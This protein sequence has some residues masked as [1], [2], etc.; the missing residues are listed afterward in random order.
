[1]WSDNDID[2]AF[3]RLNP[4][5]PEPAPFPLD[6]WLRLETQ[7]DKRLIEHAVRRKLWRIFA[8]EVAAVALVASAWWLW[9]NSPGATPAA[10]AGAANQPREAL[11]PAAGANAAGATSRGRAVKPAP[12]GPAPAGAS[13]SHSGTLASSYSPPTMRAAA[14]PEAVGPVNPAGA[15]PSPATTRAPRAGIAAKLVAGA[16]PTARTQTSGVKLRAITKSRSSSL[17]AVSAEETPNELTVT[18]PAANSLAPIRPG[19][20]H[21]HKISSGMSQPPVSEAPAI[22]GH[23]SLASAPVAASTGG[24]TD[25]SASAPSALA[26]RPV[27]LAL[28]APPPAP[29]V[30][31]VAVAVADV[32]AKPVLPALTQPP[33]FYVGVVGAPDVSTVKF[34]HVASPLPNLGITLEYRLTNRLRLTTGLLRATKHYAAHREDYDWGAYRSIVYQMDFKD[35]DGTCTVLDV[36]LNLRYDAVVHPQYRVFGSVGLSSFF[37]QR[38]RYSYSYVVNNQTRLWEQNVVN[39]NRHLF[40]LANLS[41]G[42]E[43]SLSTHWSVQAEPYVKVPLGGVGMGK[44]QLV[45]GGVFF[46]AKYGF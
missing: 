3:Q 23:E 19:A 42:Y 15:S 37:M 14:P 1:M 39:K 2:N 10:T 31:L 12:S 16:H 11:A 20:R 43:R 18:E 8:A 32:A 41:F 45:S 34:A 25:A 5:E 7:L 13:S 17:R 28:T 40:R 36:P 35:V 46:G 26:C 33:R 9:P 38:E 21:G 24:N 30:P 6:G 4:P 22:A 27:V 44:V 29:W